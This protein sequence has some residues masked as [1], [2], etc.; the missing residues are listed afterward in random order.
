VYSHSLEIHV[1]CIALT[2]HPMQH[3]NITL[4]KVLRTLIALIYHAISIVHPSH[5]AHYQTADEA[6]H[7]HS[8]FRFFV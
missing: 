4:T 5:A 1:S 7:V 8:M 6:T 3:I 2:T